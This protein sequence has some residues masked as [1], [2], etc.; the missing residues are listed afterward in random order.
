MCHE[1]A[2]RRSRNHSRGRPEDR[3]EGH[4]GQEDR[5]VPRDQRRYRLEG[6][7]PI[8]F[9]GEWKGKKFKGEIETFEAPK[10]LAFTHWSAMS[11]EEDRPENYNVVRFI[12][13]PKGEK[14]TVALSQINKGKAE[15]DAK[16][17]AEF[18][19]NWQMMLDGL[20]KSVEAA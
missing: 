5:N 14:T 6:G 13:K 17:K 19:K 10:E 8:T 2:R 12:L 9:T 20:K 1:Q 15:V 7:H 3:L 11:G 16:T 18:K 4:D